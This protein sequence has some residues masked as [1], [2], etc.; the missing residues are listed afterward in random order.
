MIELKHKCL[1]SFVYLFTFCAVRQIS[2]LSVLWN[3]GISK[4]ALYFK[5]E[6]QKNVFAL[7]CH[8][9]VQAYIMHLHFV[10]LDLHI[11]QQALMKENTGISY[12]S[13]VSA[14]CK[15]SGLF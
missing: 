4:S 3:E 7:N 1:L 5:V 11:K 8:G 12:N 13:V 6:K 14:V 15:D 2:N 10:R 9:M